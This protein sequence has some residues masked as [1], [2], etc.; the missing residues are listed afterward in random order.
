LIIA[1]AGTA[2]FKPIGKFGA[3]FTNLKIEK[4]ALENKVNFF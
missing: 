1:G 3:K 2:R 4:K